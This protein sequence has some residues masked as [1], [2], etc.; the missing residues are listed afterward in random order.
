MSNPRS[1]SERTVA[2]LVPGF[3]ALDIF[4]ESDVNDDGK[5]DIFDLLELLKLLK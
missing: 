2:E 3:G 5:L 4:F 1:I